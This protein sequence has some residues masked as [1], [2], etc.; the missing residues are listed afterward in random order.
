[1]LAVPDLSS[2]YPCA[3]EILHQ[4][5]MAAAHASSK[6][7]TLKSLMHMSFLHLEDYIHFSYILNNNK[8]TKYGGRK[9]LFYF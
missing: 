2:A 7:I 9:K 6:T 1:M 8:P 3:R 5:R 4:A